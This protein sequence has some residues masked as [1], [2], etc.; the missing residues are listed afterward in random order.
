MKPTNRK[1]WLAMVLALGICT[2]RLSA[3][4]AGADVLLVNI[5]NPLPEDYQCDDLVNLY[6]Q[7]R[8]FKLAR[9][10]IFLERVVYEA[11]NSMFRKARADGVENFTITSGYRTREKQVELYAG[12]ANTNA[13]APG[14]SEHQTGLA[15]DVTTRRNAGGFETTRQYRW[16]IENC[17]DF[18][19]ILR[20]PEGAEAVTGFAYEPWHY[21]YVGED[22]ARVIH[23]NG[24]TLEEYCAAEELPIPQSALA[25]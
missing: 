13:A 6:E 20:Y 12:G 11:A 4:A 18:G 5:D 22:V 19:F 24:W 16:L 3:M 15:F 14:T 23:E 25:D 7:K 8:Y 17:W 9:S 10:D 2:S 1:K 21:R